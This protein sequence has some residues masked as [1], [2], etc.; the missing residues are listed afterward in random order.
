MNDKL[1]WGS[2]GQR[3]VTMTAERVPGSLAVTLVT[4]Q[5]SNTASWGGANPN[6]PNFESWSLSYSRVSQELP[7]AIR[8]QRTSR[9]TAAG[10]VTQFQTSYPVTAH[11]WWETRKKYVRRLRIRGFN[12]NTMDLIISRN[13]NTLHRIY[14]RWY[15]FLVGD[16]IEVA[17]NTW[18]VSYTWE[19][20]PGSPDVFVDTADLV[21]SH[22]VPPAWLNDPIYYPADTWARP[23]YHQV[24]TIPVYN[25]TTHAPF[26]PEFHA[27]CPYLLNATGYQSL[28][29]F[30]L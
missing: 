15:L 7:Y 5:Y 8:D 6:D 25:A 27:E 22:I 20:D 28:P 26:W 30:T 4:V 2:D 10:G 9:Y 24:G 13:A 19:Y 12:A 1:P 14:G 3:V 16:V 17:V 21:F 11:S 29:G 18:D 23:P